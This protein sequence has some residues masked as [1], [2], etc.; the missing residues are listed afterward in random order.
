M[1][2]TKPSIFIVTLIYM[3]CLFPEVSD[4]MGQRSVS[5]TFKT[6]ENSTLSVAYLGKYVMA[7]MGVD[8]E[9]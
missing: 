2:Q 6:L 9:F 5:R 7:V 8:R 4:R 1:G 3:F